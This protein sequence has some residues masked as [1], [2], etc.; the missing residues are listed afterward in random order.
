M[1]SLSPQMM[2]LPLEDSLLHISTNGGTIH[3]TPATMLGTAKVVVVEK[4]Q[5]MMIL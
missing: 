5:P 4:L 2:V 3:S 1:S